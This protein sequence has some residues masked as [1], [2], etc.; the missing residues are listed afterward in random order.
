MYNIAKKGKK[1]REPIP[2][3]QYMKNR[4]SRKREQRKRRGGNYQKNK[5]HFSERKHMHLQTE[6][7]YWGPY[8]GDEKKKKKKSQIKAQ[9]SYTVSE[10]KKKEDHSKHQK[11]E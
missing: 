7:G 9:K 8:T 2:K 4:C 5:K 1:I 6:R 11:S 3:V 10:T